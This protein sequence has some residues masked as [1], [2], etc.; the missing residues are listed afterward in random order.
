METRETIYKNEQWFME[1]DTW[2]NYILISSFKAQ[3]VYIRA[4][5]FYENYNKRI[6]Q[7]YIFET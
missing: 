2:Q 5:G 1:P 6:I 4:A 3:P 7:N